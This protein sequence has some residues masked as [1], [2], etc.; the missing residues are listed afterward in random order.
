ML[1]NVVDVGATHIYFV[2]P[3][4]EEKVC[5]FPL[6]QVRS[7]QVASFKQNVLSKCDTSYFGAGA[8]NCQCLLSL[9]PLPPTPRATIF[10][11]D[12]QLPT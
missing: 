1:P 3:A 11:E 12:E 10:Q 8:L 9:R 4:G 5:I 6:P 2:S 7:S